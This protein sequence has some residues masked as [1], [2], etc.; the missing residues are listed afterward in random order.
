METIQV[1]ESVGTPWRV[2]THN[3]WRLWMF[4]FQDVTNKI[5]LPNN[6]TMLNKK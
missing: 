1:V 2:E 4:C 6:H 5:V 3:N